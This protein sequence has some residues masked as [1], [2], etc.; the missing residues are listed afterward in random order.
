[1][2]F[3]VLLLVLAAAI[4]HAGW[5]AW[6]KI[7]VDRL[8]AIAFMG[9]GWSLLAVT[10]LPFLPLPD[11]A[12][13][14]YLLASVVFHTAY[15]LTLVKAY[16]IGDLSVAYPVA[17]GT[18]PLLVT[19]ISAITIRERVGLLG[20]LAVALIVAGCIGLG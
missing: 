7:S 16:R 2:T 15:T 11:P 18:A 9:A 3:E 6:L 12:A 20:A 13:W 5:N 14:P 10:A 19:V 17:R 4:I 1:M 8:V